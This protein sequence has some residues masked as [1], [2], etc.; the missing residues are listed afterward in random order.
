MNGKTGSVQQRSLLPS[1]VPH[2]TWWEPRRSVGRTVYLVFGL[3]TVGWNGALV[4][5]ATLPCP[6]HQ[7]PAICGWSWSIELA[8]SVAALSEAI[9]LVILLLAIRMLSIR[10]LGTLSEGLVIRTGLESRVVP[11]RAV[12]LPSQSR[13]DKFVWLSLLPSAK[14]FGRPGRRIRVPVELASIISS[15]VNQVQTQPTDGSP[16]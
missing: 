7:A 16:A 11:W 10:Q 5:L 2:V 3:L 9:E 8:V 4:Y 6:S 14:R 1:E 12:R 13:N 15:H